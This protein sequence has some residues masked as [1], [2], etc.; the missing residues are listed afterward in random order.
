MITSV[1]GHLPHHL[2]AGPDHPVLPEPDDLA[3]RR[4]DVARGST[5]RAPGSASGQP[6]VAKGHSADE[7]HVSST[8]GSRVERDARAGALLRLLLR[9]GADHLA[10]R[11]RPDRQ[12]VAP[13]ELARQAPVGGLLQRGDREPVLRL[14]VEAHAPLAQRLDRRLR[15]LLHPAP[16]LQRDQRLDARVAALARPDRVPVV[17]ALDELPAFL[18]PGDDGRVCLGLRQPARSPAA[19]F[20]LPSRPITIGSGKPVVAS[21]LE[22]ERDRGRA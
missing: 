2:E 3:G 5:P 8:S 6:S 9:R 17:L 12:L 22:V 20:I 7:N 4:V 16:P 14:G 15:R 13:P 11:G 19:S 21:D 1:N 18:D 10:V